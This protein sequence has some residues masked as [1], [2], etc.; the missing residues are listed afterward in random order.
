[1]TQERSRGRGW[2][3]RFGLLVGVVLAF[4]SL[5]KSPFL[6]EPNPEKTAIRILHRADGDRGRFVEPQDLPN[7]PARSDSFNQASPA[8]IASRDTSPTVPPAE[9]ATIPVKSPL[10]T[11]TAVGTTP[12]R[13]ARMLTNE[14]PR[15]GNTTSSDSDPASEDP[16]ALLKQARFLIKA[17]LAPMAA[18]PLRKVVREAP[19]TRAAQEAQQT[20]DSLSRN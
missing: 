8:R 13:S 19:G 5:S 1:M 9:Y 3:I 20:L 12:G 4:V 7:L 11:I 16:Q 14:E 6:R 10:V 2:G 15:S 17:G 18:D